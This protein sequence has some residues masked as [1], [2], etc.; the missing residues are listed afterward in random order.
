MATA[1]HAERQRVET[2]RETEQNVAEV[3][4]AISHVNTPR[5][6][7]QFGENFDK[8]FKEIDK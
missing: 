4:H 5:E 1:Q 6:I 8:I 3:D 2:S 7:G